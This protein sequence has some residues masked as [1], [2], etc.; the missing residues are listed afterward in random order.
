VTTISANRYT[1]TINPDQNLVVNTQHALGVIVVLDNETIFTTNTTD[2]V[3]I[4]ST[5]AAFTD[6]NS[7]KY[8]AFTV[9]P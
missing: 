1:L 2:T 6:Y 3:I 9:K 5:V 8:I 7:G 4:P